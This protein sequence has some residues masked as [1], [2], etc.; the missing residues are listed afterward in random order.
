M[1]QLSD[2]LNLGVTTKLQMH[3]INPWIVL[4]SL[5]KW[6]RATGSETH[7][8]EPESLVLHVLTWAVPVTSLSIIFFSSLK[9]GGLC[10]HHKVY[11]KI[12]KVISIKC[13][14]H[15]RCSM[16]GSHLCHKN[17]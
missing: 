10:Q 7:K 3:I 4:M 11:M 8:P 2:S 5:V 15:T 16:D 17:I 1:F 12:K 13:L 14:V 9:W 6:E